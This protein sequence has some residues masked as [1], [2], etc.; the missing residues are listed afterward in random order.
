MGVKKQIIFGSKRRQTS[1]WLW[2]WDKKGSNICLPA[3]DN[4]VLS[5]Y[6]MDYLE[7]P[8]YSLSGRPEGLDLAIFL[9]KI[10][11]L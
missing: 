5:L 3:A 11:D 2:G 6:G 10:S 4:A 8:S 7:E 9:L 1:E